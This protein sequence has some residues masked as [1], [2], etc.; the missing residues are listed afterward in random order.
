MLLIFL[1][2]RGGWHKFCQSLDR[3][4]ALIFLIG[5]GFIIAGV[6]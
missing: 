5:A 3:S 4:P 2:N 1:F 6:V